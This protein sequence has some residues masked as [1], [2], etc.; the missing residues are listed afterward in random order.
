[1]IETKPT[2]FVIT[3]Q[4]MN[5]PVSSKVYGDILLEMNDP[6]KTVITFRDFY[7]KAEVSIR[8]ELITHLEHQLVQLTIA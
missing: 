3:M 4:G 8:A 7:G 5:I 6:K 1:M 2:R